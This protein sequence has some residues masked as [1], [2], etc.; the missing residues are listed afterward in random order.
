MLEFYPD[1]PK[2][3]LDDLRKMIQPT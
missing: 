2:S 1:E 3:P